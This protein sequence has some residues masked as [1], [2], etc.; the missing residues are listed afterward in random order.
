M[1]S[2]NAV[3]ITGESTKNR[4]V[5]IDR[6]TSNGFIKLN[7]S[8]IEISDQVKSESKNSKHENLKSK[9]IP[10]TTNDRDMPD[11]LEG[12]YEES[13]IMSNKKFIICS[14]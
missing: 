13:D 5:M 12:N 9:F 14:R 1:D 2:N 8:N 3:K 7:K 11:F 4:K 10:L 6:S